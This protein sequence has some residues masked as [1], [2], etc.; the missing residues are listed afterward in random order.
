MVG[1]DVPFTT[2][3]EGL[4]VELDSI[5]TA[6]EGAIE[7]VALVSLEA[8]GVGAEL[9]PAIDGERVSLPAIDGALVALVSLSPIKLPKSPRLKKPTLTASVAFSEAVQGRSGPKQ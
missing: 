8:A 5:E 2:S 6:G 4:K 9:M 3:T 1:D 7:S